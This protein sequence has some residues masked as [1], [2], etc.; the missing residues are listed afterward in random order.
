MATGGCDLRIPLFCDGPASDAGGRLLLLDVP[1]DH[2]C[3]I[4]AAE[5]E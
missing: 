1:L 4:V 2:D 3:R 5:P